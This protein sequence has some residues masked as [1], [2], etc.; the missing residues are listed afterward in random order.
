[1]W[2]CQ[3]PRNPYISVPMR[4]S[5]Q[6]GQDKR[7]ALT[8]NDGNCSGAMRKILHLEHECKK[9]VKYLSAFAIIQSAPKRNN[10]PPPAGLDTTACADRGPGQVGDTNFRHSSFSGVYR[11]TSL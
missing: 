11:N 1:M 4:V 3:T 8:C 10:F 2:I 5:K 6:N 9:S 7:D